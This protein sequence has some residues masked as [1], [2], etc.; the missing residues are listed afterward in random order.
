MKYPLSGLPLLLGCLVFCLPATLWAQEQ[1]YAGL[2]EQC[3]RQASQVADGVDLP[4]SVLQP[5]EQALQAEGYLRQLQVP[6]EDWQAQ[7]LRVNYGLMLAEMG[8]FDKATEAYSGALQYSADPAPLYLNRANLYLYTQ[9][10]ELALA[11][12]QYLVSRPQYRAQG[13]YN[14][15]LVH[16]YAGM[17]L[18]AQDDFSA[19]AAEFPESYLEWVVN[20]DLRAIYPVQ[21]AETEPGLP[22]FSD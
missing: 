14:R 20:E 11:D 6:V 22:G 21:L 10:Y 7:V 18:Q 17:Y 1:D 5:C 4:P 8:F 19:L 16:H 13:L 9:A 2:V 3:H 15:A 12:L